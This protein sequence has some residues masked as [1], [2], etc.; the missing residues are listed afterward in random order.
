MGREN[1]RNKFL[2]ISVIV[3]AI[4]TMLV[5]YFG[6]LGTVWLDDLMEWTIAI[7]ASLSGL[8]ILPEVFYGR[9]V[10]KWT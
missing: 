5:P 2:L 10:W 3:S 7:V 4:A 8:L 1:F 9:K 6:I